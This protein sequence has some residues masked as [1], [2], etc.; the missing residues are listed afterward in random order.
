MRVLT[1]IREKVDYLTIRFD[2]NF[3]NLNYDFV[4][5]LDTLVD[6]SPTI[7]LENLP[8][9][10]TLEHVIA[11]KQKVIKM[12]DLNHNSMGQV[13][14][15]NTWAISYY[16]ELHLQ[17]NF[18]FTY[19]FLL[20]E[21]LSLF[22]LSLNSTRWISRLDYAIDVIEY[23]DELE[24]AFNSMP[25]EKSLRKPDGSISCSW[26]RIQTKRLTTV[27]YNKRLDI[28]AK[29]E[30]Y[31]MVDVFQNEIYKKYITDNPI[32]TRIE[33]R[34][35]AMA[36]KPA[37][38]KERHTLGWYL[39]GNL[40]SITYEDLE[41]KGLI[42]KDFVP[43]KIKYDKNKVPVFD[44]SDSVLEWKKKNALVMLNAYIKNCVSYWL[45][46]EMVDLLMDNYPPLKLSSILDKKIENLLTK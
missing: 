23:Q 32:I 31:N 45:E 41:K 29:K 38:W 9:K 12:Y 7:E 28:I 37:K 34:R 10:F 11:G 20:I 19:D 22:W 39:D 43:N 16:T 2:K 44:I 3:R 15:A 46:N 17:G 6:N 36:L 4:R 25:W 18:W 14:I 30:K 13:L 8:F 27:Y 5:W 40:A 26:M 21:V 42:F 33:Q 24:Q 35:N 1:K